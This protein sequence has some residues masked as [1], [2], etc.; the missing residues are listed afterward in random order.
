MLRIS[1]S[2][3]I[4]VLFFGGC[5]SIKPYPRQKR[6][7]VAI[8]KIQNRTKEKNMD[9]NLGVI[10][11][12]LL[13]E[14]YR[15]QRVR[16]IE[17]DRIDAVL[18][19]QALGQSGI[20]NTKK[21]MNIGQMLGADGVLI[22]HVSHIKDNMQELKFS[23]GANRFLSIIITLSARIIH[24]RTGEILSTA[25]IRQKSSAI[26]IV[27]GSTKT[28]KIDRGVIISKIIYEGGKKLAHDLARHIP[29]RN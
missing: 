2:A 13:T 15:Y 7:L 10:R 12:L 11:D 1:L 24:V 14:L 22:G 5:A 27:V 25:L 20:I 28:G 4:I 3:I 26:E 17:R 23:K 19:E 29:P 16:L 21:A 18:K 8:L 9:T 6:Y